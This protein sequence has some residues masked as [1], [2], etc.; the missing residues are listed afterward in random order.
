MSALTAALVADLAEATEEQRAQLA[1]LLRPY[2]SPSKAQASVS[3]WLRGADQIAAYIGAPRSRV[4]ALASA[5]RIPVERDGSAL[6]AHTSALD[7]WLR[8]GG[9]KRP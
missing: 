3:Q 5:G 8:A 2:L 9:A 1:E 4:Y 6:I 7:D